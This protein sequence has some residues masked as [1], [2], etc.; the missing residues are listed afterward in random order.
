MAVGGLNED[1]NSIYNEQFGEISA[2]SGGGT[3]DA[4]C[5]S[6]DRWCEP[7]GRYF[8]ETYQGGTSASTAIA[9]G[10]AGLVRA[11][12]SGLSAPEV[13]QQL[14]NTADGSNNKLDAAEAVAGN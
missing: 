10:I 11:Q 3:L 14:I 8:Y 2:L 13:R 5:P 9:A 1:G 6:P 12:N 7:N 4:Y